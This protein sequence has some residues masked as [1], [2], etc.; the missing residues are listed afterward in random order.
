MSDAETCTAEHDEGLEVGICPIIPSP[1]VIVLGVGLRDIC[2]V[3][4]WPGETVETPLRTSA[5][6]KSVSLIRPFAWISRSS[7]PILAACAI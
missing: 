2:I 6:S 3:E 4:G 1:S 5:R 7:W